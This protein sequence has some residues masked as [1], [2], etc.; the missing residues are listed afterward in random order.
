[1]GLV[2]E[3]ELATFIEKHIAHGRVALN[4]HDVMPAPIDVILTCP[5]GERLILELERKDISPVLLQLL[6]TLIP[7]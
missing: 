2:A 3:I 7:E 4:S 6:R 5:C 1:M